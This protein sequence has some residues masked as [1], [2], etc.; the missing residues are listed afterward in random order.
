MIVLSIDS[1]IAL[2]KCLA[3]K[4]KTCRQVQIHFMSKES[5]YNATFFHSTVIPYLKMPQDFQ[6]QKS[7]S[8]TTYF[9][10]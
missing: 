10:I 8:I 7:S 3:F 2:K 9:V 6:I 5:T 1:N 4:S